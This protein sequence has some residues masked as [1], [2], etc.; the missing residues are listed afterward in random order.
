MT[1]SII[2]PVYNLGQY[3]SEAI[4]SVLHQTYSDFELIVVDDGSTDNTSK[5]LRGFTDPRINVK[6]IANS[7][8]SIA[9]NRG[10]D[11]ASGEYIAFLDADDRWLPD[12]LEKQISLIEA[13]S[14]LGLVFSDFVRFEGDRIY[15]DTLFTFVPELKVLRKKS[16]SIVNSYVI[17]EGTFSALA[18]TWEMATWL[19]TVLI[20]TCLV[21]DI[22]FPPGVRLCEDYYYMLK[23]YERVNAAYINE[24]LVEVRRHECNSYTQAKQMLQPKVDVI[25]MFMEN[26]DSEIHR[27]VLQKRLG[28]AWMALGYSNFWSGDVFGSAN[29]YRMAILN[30]GNVWNAI[31]HLAALP[32]VPLL[33][34]IYQKK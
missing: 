23:V 7:G 16:G 20:K 28:K 32:L 1:V 24:P 8:V 29:A 33:A 19:Q 11:M 9:R 5:V 21:G 18:S 2:M 3:I 12:K 30:K 27:K 13:D 15:P 17:T 22:R 31:R 10:L 25:T 6:H 4:E 26:M 34:R 14:S